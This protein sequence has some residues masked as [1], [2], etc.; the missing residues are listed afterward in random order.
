MKVE[1]IEIERALKTIKTRAEKMR[2]LAIK[3]ETRGE[4]QTS[5]V[6]ETEAVGIEWAANVLRRAMD[7]RPQARGI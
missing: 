3:Y 7:K 1:G 4:R 5:E 2:K 6:M